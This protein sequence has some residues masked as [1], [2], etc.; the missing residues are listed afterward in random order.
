MIVCVDDII[1][2]ESN[3]VDIADLKA[4]LSRQLHTLDL[5]TLQYFLGIEVARSKMG[6]VSVAAQ[7]CF[8]IAFRARDV[9]FS[10][11]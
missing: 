8:G 5:G 10:A 7:V 2:Y 3:F 1:V 4:Y 11:G 6:Y 9:G